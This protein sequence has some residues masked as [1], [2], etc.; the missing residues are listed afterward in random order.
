VRRES[1][2]VPSFGLRKMTEVWM[3]DL[4]GPRFDPDE[5]AKVL[6][7]GQE[8]WATHARLMLLGNPPLAMRLLPWLMARHEFSGLSLGVI[9]NPRNPLL[10]SDA[11]TGVPI[12][13]VR[14]DNFRDG[15]ED[16]ETLGMLRTAID[17]AT[18][19]NEKDPAKLK[20]IER[21][22]KL[23]EETIPSIIRSARDFS[24]D[25][26]ALQ[27]ARDQAGEL[28]SILSPQ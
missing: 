17:E 16:Y 7:P 18:G 10:Y 11:N 25:P 8:L 13:S 21:S 3:P 27:A 2:D 6:Q 12:G 19:R 15:M 28:L 23:F 5:W 9:N 26:T 24:W 22:Q 20:A 1:R 4:S 14:F